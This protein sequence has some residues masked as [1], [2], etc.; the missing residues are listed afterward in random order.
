MGS[1]GGDSPWAERFGGVGTLTPT[2]DQPR[3][4]VGGVTPARSPS[5]SQCR[6]FHDQVVK[7]VAEE[8]FLQGGVTEASSTISSPGRA[9]SQD[10]RSWE[11]GL[12][13]WMR[14]GVRL[15]AEPIFYNP[16]QQYKVH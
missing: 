12:A 9:C 14:D 11:L 2:K 13:P 7:S 4:P 5:S 10:G 6:G 15:R 1:S 16:C 8:T 3:V